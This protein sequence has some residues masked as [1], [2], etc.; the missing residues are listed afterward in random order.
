MLAPRRVPDRVHALPAGDEPG[1][2]A[3][4]LRVPDRDLRAH[5]HGRRRTPPATTGRRLPRTPATSPGR[6]PAARRSSLTEAL[7]PQV[8]QVV[9]DLRARLRARRRRGSAPRRHDRSG[10]APRSSRRGGVRDLPAAELLRL[11]GAGAR[12]RRRSQRRGSA[13]RSHT[14]TRSRSGCLEAPGAYGC[15]LAIGEG[16]SAG[17]YQSYGGPHYGFLAA[18]SEFIRRMPGRISGETAGLRGQARLRPDS[19]RRGSSTFVG[20]RPPPTSRRT[21]RC[22]RWPASSTSRGWDRRGCASWGDLP[23]RSRATRR[24]V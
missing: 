4:D 17:N 9:Q 19:C 23:A 18:R 22:S 7:N 13:C 12:P 11:P 24:N 1:G 2:A 5:R 20:R 21:R 6:R 16:Q 14:S 8:R 3:G 10:R 15:A